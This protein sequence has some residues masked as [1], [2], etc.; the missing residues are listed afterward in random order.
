MTDRTEWKLLE[1]QFQDLLNME[2]AHLPSL[3]APPER[4]QPQSP[5][6]MREKVVRDLEDRVQRLIETYVS[7]PGLRLAE[8]KET[9]AGK[10]AET[11]AILEAT[12]YETE[13]A[14][15]LVYKQHMLQ[16]ADETSIHRWDNEASKIY[17]LSPPNAGKAITDNNPYVN[18]VDIDEF[19]V[20]SEVYPF[21]EV[22]KTWDQELYIKY[23]SRMHAEV[24]GRADTFLEVIGRDKQRMTE[25]ARGKSVPS[26]AGE[27]EQD[28]AKLKEEIRT[29]ARSLGFPAM[30]VTR[31]DRR[32]IAENMDDELPYDTLI[33][34]AHEWPLETFKKIPADNALAAFT[35]YRDGGHNIHKVADFLRSKGYKCLARVSSDG[36]IKFA[37]HAVNA[38]MGNYSTFGICIFPE[39]GT[40]TKVAGII[41]EAK[42]PLDRPRDWNIE[43]FCSRCRS[44]QKTCPA[45]AIPK[46]E[47]RFRGALKRQT[48]H[49]RC[50]E[51][52]ATSYECNLCTRICP[53][54]VLGY[55][56]AMQALPRY[57]H[58]NL[59]REE[60]DAELLRSSWEGG[61]Q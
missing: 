32:Y 40:R 35:S 22:P 1:Q 30:G 57:L 54:S 19:D 59:Y 12:E 8:V 48:Y 9:L 60:V 25:E 6:L 41:T 23:F 5:K 47:K 50:F 26:V 46:D 13:Q 55:E 7:E 27:Q 58:Y 56:Q 11:A 42:L 38:G 15:W 39:M 53:F 37:P 16:Q 49:Q 44:C 28:L 3:P 61:A 31:L 18:L 43:E 4:R 52:M 36:A 20:A 29:Y 14:K 33:L 51:F 10:I 17:K 24:T 21:F 45:G 34:L 2:K